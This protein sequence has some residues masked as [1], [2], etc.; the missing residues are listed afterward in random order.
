MTRT[1]YQGT[2][3]KAK[4]NLKGIC[5]Y[6]EGYIFDLGPISLDKSTRKMKELQQYLGETY[7][8][9]C[10]PATMTDTQDTLP[11][12]DMPTIIPDTG[13]EN[14]KTDIDMTYL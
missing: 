6:L 13:V 2:E 14:P 5:S 9:R 4:T 10:Q 7:R 12:P 8:D 11:D 1:K 3:P